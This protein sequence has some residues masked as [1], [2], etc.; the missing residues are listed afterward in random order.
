MLIKKISPLTGEENSMEIDVTQE[1][2]EKWQNGTLIQNAMPRLS[3]AEREFIK[4]GYTQE[5]WDKIFLSDENKSNR[6]D[7]SQE[8]MLAQMLAGHTDDD[9]WVHENCGGKIFE[10]GDWLEGTYICKCTNCDEEWDDKDSFDQIRF[11]DFKKN[12]EAKRNAK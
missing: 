10:D 2:I 8:E 7:K 11:K 5:D 6:K 1:Q 12:V 3:S 9:R 4:T